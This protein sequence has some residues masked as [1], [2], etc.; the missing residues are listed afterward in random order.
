MTRVNCIIEGCSGFIDLS[1]PVAA[2]CSYIC[3]DHPRAVQCRA[4]VGRPEYD[5]AKDESDKDVHFQEIQFDPELGGESPN[6][7]GSTE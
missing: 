1:E 4:V 5:A 3:K 7:D 6:V 2:K